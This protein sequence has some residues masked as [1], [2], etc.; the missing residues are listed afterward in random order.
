[1]KFIKDEIE[2]YLFQILLI[3]LSLDRLGKIGGQLLGLYIAAQ[4][5]LNFP[6]LPT[7]LLTFFNPFPS[8]LRY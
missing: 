3:V 2:H 7:E 6:H 8:S 1:M 5:D 4:R